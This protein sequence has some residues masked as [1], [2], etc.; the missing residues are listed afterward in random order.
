MTENGWFTVNNLT[1]FLYAT[2][3]LAVG[4]VMSGL[5][6]L[7]GDKAGKDDIAASRWL[8]VV[9]SVVGV[10]GGGILLATQQRIRTTQVIS[11]G[12]RGRVVVKLPPIAAMR[13]KM[14]RVLN[15]V[16]R[17]TDWADKP[18]K[19]KGKEAKKFET[20]NGRVSIKV[21]PGAS[22]KD[23]GQAFT[24]AFKASKV[25]VD[26]D[27]G[28]TTSDS[29]PGDVIILDP[30]TDVIPWRREKQWTK[31]LSLGTVLDNGFWGWT[32][33]DAAIGKRRAPTKSQICRRGKTPYMNSS[34][35]PGQTSGMAPGY[36][37][38]IKC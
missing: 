1:L 27:T 13:E 16:S 12:E 22:G 32:Y 25:K 6:I 4:L 28:K 11:E 38:P 35:G 15:L 19:K 7:F 23:V 10:A 17:A 26:P 29:K 30:E 3:I 34:T 14:D 33:W 8:I 9:G 2:V 18:K 21:W 5:A 24:K 31:A 36:N 20:L 37:T